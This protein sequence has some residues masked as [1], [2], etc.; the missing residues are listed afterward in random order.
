MTSWS[1]NYAGSSGLP[2]PSQ[3]QEELIRERAA[4]VSNLHQPFHPRS[5][6][7]LF[8]FRIFISKIF[9]TF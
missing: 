8:F 3:H 9:T 2:S 1:E 4:T 7:C 5:Q 6:I